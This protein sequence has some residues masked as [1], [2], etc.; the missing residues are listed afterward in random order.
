MP[1]Q[2]PICAYCKQPIL[3]GSYIT[4][5]GKMWHPEHFLCAACSLPIYENNFSVHE[6]KPYHPACYVERFVPKCA[7]CGKPLVGEY[8]I[9]AWGT[10]FHKTH[11]KEF[12]RCTYCGRLVPQQQQEHGA[13][14]GSVV[15]C[16][17]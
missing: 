10:R 7:Y 2:P 5:L 1:T 14:S 17:I 15:R 3:E 8:L 16:P 11:E 13:K 4:A 9:D 12:P 6:G